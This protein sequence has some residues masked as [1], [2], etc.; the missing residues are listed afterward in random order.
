MPQQQQSKLI[1]AESP[2]SLQNEIWRFFKRYKKSI[3]LNDERSHLLYT[4]S[5]FK[6][7]PN[8]TTRLLSSDGNKNIVNLLLPWGRYIGSRWASV[9]WKPSLYTHILYP[10]SVS[11]GRVH[12]YLDIGKWQWKDF[13]HQIQSYWVSMDIGYTV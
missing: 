9:S 6:Y 3:Y 7:F 11:S 4:S 10:R 8:T 2:L 12:I 13:L 5:F 1:V